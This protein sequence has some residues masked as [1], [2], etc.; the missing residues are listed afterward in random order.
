MVS[1]IQNL[2]GEHLKLDNSRNHKNP[3]KI[4]SVG[5]VKESQQVTK[6]RLDRY[7]RQFPISL[8][9]DYLAKNIHFM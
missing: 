8:S 1:R 7:L 4:I 6:S 5:Y 9:G 3:Q 2:I